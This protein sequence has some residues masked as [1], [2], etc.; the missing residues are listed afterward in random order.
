MVVG[1]DGGVQRAIGGEGERSRELK[2]CFTRREGGGGN[3]GAIVRPQAN[4]EDKG[5]EG[6]FSVMETTPVGGDKGPVWVW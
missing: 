2:R 4:V 5:L 6:G 1:Y 3:D